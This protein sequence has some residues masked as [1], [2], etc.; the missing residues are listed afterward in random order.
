MLAFD[1]SSD[2]YWQA[3]IKSHM[4]RQDAGRCNNRK[5]QH[6]S[7]TLTVSSLSPPSTLLQQAKKDKWHSKFLQ[8]I[9]E[10]LPSWELYTTPMYW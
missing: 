9:S 6:T 5:A 1:S 3:P 8:S 2:E 4:Q 10:L 7:Y